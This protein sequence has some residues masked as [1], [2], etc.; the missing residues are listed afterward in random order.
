MLL[1]H[2]EVLGCS[3]PM[4]QKH[5]EGEGYSGGERQ[6]DGSVTQI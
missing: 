2:L 6:E 4:E 1:F 3:D 5:Q